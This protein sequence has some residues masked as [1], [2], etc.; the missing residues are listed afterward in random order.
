MLDLDFRPHVE[1]VIGPVLDWTLASTSNSRVWRVRAENGTWSV[2]LLVDRSSDVHVERRV[3]DHLDANSARRIHAVVDLGQAH[4]VVA[5]Y[6]DGELVADRLSRAPLEPDEADAL[7]VQ[8]RRVI[9]QIATV[10]LHAAGYGRLGSGQAAGAR[11]WS[12]ALRAYLEE[13]RRKG[14]AT[15]ALRYTAISTAL[16][17][18]AHRLDEECGPPR[19]IATD[20][21]SR[22]F[23]IT[24][25]GTLV[26]LNFPVVRQGHPA[27]SYG[28]LQLHLDDTPVADALADGPWP[29]WCLHFYAAYQAFVICVHAERFAAAPIEEVTPWGRHRPLLDLLDLHLMLM[30]NAL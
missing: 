7:A 17:R 9:D 16:D 25:D 8:Y 11:R 13:Q 15:A 14:P 23:L 1:Q 10:P 24:D 29:R 6:L 20:V 3:L 22:N 5:R 28:A 2:K 26:A 4:L 12:D 18:L 21:N 30:E 19:T 27:M